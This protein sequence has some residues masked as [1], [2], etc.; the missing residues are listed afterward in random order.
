MK[1]SRALSFSIFYFS[2]WRTHDP[3]LPISSTKGSWDEM[4]TLT[5]HFPLVVCELLA[6]YL[7]NTNHMLYPSRYWLVGW[8]DKKGACS[9]NCLWPWRCHLATH[10]KLMVA[11]AAHSTP[12][13]LPSTHCFVFVYLYFSTCIFV[14]VHLW[15]WWP[16]NPPL[17][18]CVFS[19]IIHFCICNADGCLCC[20]LNPTGPPST[21]HF[22]FVN[23]CFFGVFVKLI[24]AFADYSNP[25]DYHQPT[26]LHLCKCVFAFFSVDISLLPS[27][28]RHLHLDR[29]YLHPAWLQGLLNDDHI[30]VS[31]IYPV[32]MH[33]LSKQ[34]LWIT[35][36]IF[37]AFFL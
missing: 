6:Q 11:F 10:V 25:L 7:F 1:R 26:A 19:F 5:F 15:A 3:Q 14:F 23:L 17:C 21:H 13:G 24:V 30:Y 33:T 31:I 12:T 18:V 36:I 8:W 22:V 27:R 16:I 29:V 35:V 4:V 32:C 9:L 28:L 2:V 37:A 20:P 34:L